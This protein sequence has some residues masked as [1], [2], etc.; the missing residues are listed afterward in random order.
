MMRRSGAGRFDGDVCCLLLTV[1]P[2]R[3]SPPAIVELHL[4][5]LR[6]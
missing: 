6:G 1:E 5:G 3:V 4:R 2:W